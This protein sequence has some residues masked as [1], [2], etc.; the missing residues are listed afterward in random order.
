M[1]LSEPRFYQFAW[2]ISL[3][4]SIYYKWQDIYFNVFKIKKGVTILSK[5]T[6]NSWAIRNILSNKTSNSWAIQGRVRLPTGPRRPTCFRHKAE[7]LVTNKSSIHS[8]VYN[9]LLNVIIL[10]RYSQI[11]IFFLMDFCSSFFNVVWW[12]TSWR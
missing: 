10:N 11:F 9:S 12:T 8:G 7:L 3:I 6:S 5:K 2:R 4:I 1:I